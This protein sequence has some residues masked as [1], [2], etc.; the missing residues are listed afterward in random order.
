M[1]DLASVLSALR[2]ADGIR[3]VRRDLST[4]E[5]VGVYCDGLC[6]R[7]SNITVIDS[8]ITDQRRVNVVDAH[9]YGHHQYLTDDLLAAP[10][11]LASKQEA[12][13]EREA[14]GICLAPER[15]VEACL[16]GCE[17]YGEF[18]DALGITADA[19]V[20]WLALMRQKYG[21]RPVRTGRYEIVFDPLPV[22]VR[23]RP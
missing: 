7:A 9:E 10:P 21:S 8:R 5:N 1:K 3:L 17:T 16:L 12:L 15:M 18:A 19:F 4:L 6:I 2:A 11:L 14:A 22:K 23:E 13:A 20:C